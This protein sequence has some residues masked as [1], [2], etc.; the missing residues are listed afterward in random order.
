VRR[1]SLRLTNQ[2]LRCGGIFNL[3]L[4]LMLSAEC[5]SEEF[6]KSARI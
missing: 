3:I 4:N 2:R 1:S 6:R 5:A